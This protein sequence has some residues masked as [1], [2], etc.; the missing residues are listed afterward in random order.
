MNFTFRL[1]CVN[2]IV[3]SIATSKA[4]CKCPFHHDKE[5]GGADHFQGSIFKCRPEIR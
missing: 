2:L 1:F 4:L 3:L 5:D